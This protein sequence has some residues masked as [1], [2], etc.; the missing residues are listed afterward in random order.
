MKI[1]KFIISKIFLRKPIVGICMIL[2]LCMADYAT[3]SAARSI[4]STW[5]GYQE[6][7]YIDQE[8]VYVANLAPESHLG[9]MGE[10]DSAQRTQAVY[11]YL[12]SNFNYALYTDGF[13]VSVPNR[14]DMEITLSYM[15]EEYYKL[16][17][18]DL[19]QGED[20]DFDYQLDREIPVLIG[21]GLNNTYPVG[22]RIVID[23]STLGCPITLKVRGVLQPNAY[24]TNFYALNSKTYCN[25]SIIFPVNEEFM[26]NAGMDLKWN[27]LM[28]LILIETTKEKVSNLGDVIEENLGLKFNF[29][30]QKENYDYFNE[31]YLY[32]LKTI[33]AITLTL[34]III[35][36][37]TV[38]TGLVSVRLMLKDFT[39]NL[40]VGLS[41]SK[42]RKMLYGYFGIISF[43]CLAIIFIFDA[44][45]S[46]SSWLRKD[47]SSVTYGLFGLIGIDWLAF[48]AIVFLDIVIGAVIVEI[49]LRKIKKIPISL[50][51]LQ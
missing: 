6:T 38:W 12:N 50:G 14:D 15:N 31:Y 45:N 41:Y 10:T 36:C 44:S 37:V 34:L 27:G 17:Q 42:L 13:V 3:F 25:F 51:V 4:L 24:H 29:Y 47:P 48:L 18:F 30:S 7:K 2:L 23:N 20:L 43:V 8:G 9:F 35:T 22:S 28:D 33:A 32:A 49:M 16:N 26:D 11:D 19:L 46:Y 1:F 21:K 40:L 5:Q 39:I